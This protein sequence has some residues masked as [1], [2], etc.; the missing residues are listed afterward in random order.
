MKYLIVELT[1]SLEEV[2]LSCLVLKFHDI[3]P[4]SNGRLR[5]GRDGFMFNLDVRIFPFILVG[6]LFILSLVADLLVVNLVGDLMEKVL[7]LVSP[8][9]NPI[10]NMVQSLV[11]FRLQ[12]DLQLVQFIVNF[13]H[14]RLVVLF[15]FG[16][17]LS[18]RFI[19]AV[20][21]GEEGICHVVKVILDFHVLCVHVTC[22]HDS[23]HY[24]SC[25]KLHN[26]I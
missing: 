23:S 15:E 10:G 13:F 12:V 16:E 3:L 24:Q 20:K 6:R 11:N 17:S 21:H 2:F 18:D 14:C 8:F 22:S 7:S 26:L 25:S 19:H 1:S 5:N 9:A 4:V